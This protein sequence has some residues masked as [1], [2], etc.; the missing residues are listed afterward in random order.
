MDV[1]EQQYV[2]VLASDAGLASLTDSFYRVNHFLPDDQVLVTIQPD[3]TVADAI[4]LMQEHRFSQLPVV[5]GNQVLGVF[6]YRSFSVRILEIGQPAGMSIGDL[7]IDEFIEDLRFVH[8]N[9]D[10]AS[11]YDL[12]DRDDAVLVGQ[13]ERL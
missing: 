13:P 5:E 7:P 12:L 3:T 2:S 1:M 6:S 4:R 9:D 11:A 10:P 8:I